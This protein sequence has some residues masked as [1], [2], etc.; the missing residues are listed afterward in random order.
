MRSLTIFDKILCEVDTALRA[1]SPPVKRSCQR[2]NPATLIDDG[3]LSADEKRMVSGLMRVN[4][5]G[6]VCA[7]ALYQGQALTAQLTTVKAQ[8]LEAAAEEIDHLAWCE[9]R[10]QELNSQPSK[11]NALWYGGSF[12]LGAFAGFLG[13]RWSLGFVAETERQV[14]AHITQHLDKVPAHDLKTHA[15]LMQMKTDEAQHAETA[16]RAG[17]AELPVFIK[18]LMHGVSRVLTQGSY[19]I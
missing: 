8:M 2:E 19:Y 10:L 7:Q 3:V 16:T 12:L 9:Q 17:G 6:E 4:H 11:L 5:S 13:D 14:T 1:L 18:R 15:I